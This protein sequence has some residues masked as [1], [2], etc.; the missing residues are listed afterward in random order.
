MTLAQRLMVLIGSSIF[1]LLLLAGINY[2]QMG[3]VYL[4]ANYS[5]ENIVP[6]ILLL[7]KAILEL[8]HLR[9]RIYRHALNTDAKQKA[10][11]EI[12]IAEART[13]I[14]KNFKDYE[15]LLS[16]DE[17]RRLLA[18][19]QA[20]FEA[21][22]KG[23]DHALE[24][25]RA[26]KQEE[27]RELLTTYAAQAEK[28]NND[29]IAHMKYNE[30]M[31]QQ[32]AAEGAATKQNA[33]L[34]A[35]AI[36][37]LALLTACGFGYLT[38]R[39]LN[40]RI[41]EANRLVERIASGDL[42]AN[43]L[44]PSQD[45]VG[46]LLQ[47]LDKMRADLSR[48]IGDIV[49][50]ANSI[51]TSANDLSTAA[52]QVSI[53]TENQSNATASAAA[54]V[55]ELTVSIDHVGSSAADAS[56][57]ADQAGNQ[58][59]SS[60]ESVASA[61]SRITEVANQVEHTAQQMEVL[62]SHVQQIDNI[63]VVIR[64]VADQTNLLALNAAIEAARAGEQGRGFAVVADEVR[65]LAERTTASVKEISAVVSTIQE[66]ASAAV[67]S[68]QTSRDVVAQV[69]VAAGEASDSM[70][71]IRQ[72]AETVQQSIETI[73]DALREQRTTSTDLARNVEAIAQMSEENS[74]AVASVADT[75]NR[76]VGV[77][78]T[79]RNSVARFRL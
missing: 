41:G 39:N 2:Q 56:S 24:V 28:F 32:S 14:A 13:T 62:S 51:A 19:E 74:A 67:T 68:M 58:A 37:V 71:D 66:G 27:A 5:N 47:S 38:L 15:A 10:E 43:N 36:F 50:G 48:T 21:Y 31:G 59:V 11:L 55:E 73:S 3:K 7:D 44:R 22:N 35:V 16:N 54:A 46:K 78:D 76:L 40:E 60:G 9:V 23:M 77:S 33:T 1:S 52:N 72:S 8:G 12:K 30:Q 64:D 6:S 17:D 26:N 45:E 34:V 69:V 25:S 42:S 29:L 79:L 65:K 53:S 18:T 49:S 20:S 61:S 75:A 70:L 63:T 57:Q 4:A